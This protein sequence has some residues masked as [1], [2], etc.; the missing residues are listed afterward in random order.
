MTH[1]DD[2]ASSRTDEAVLKLVRAAGDSSRAELAAATG[3]A[4]STINQAVSR[5]L[6]RGLLRQITTSPK[7]AGSGSGRPATRLAL[8][9]SSGVTA[10][11]DFGHN[12]VRVAVADARDGF[13]A[14]RELLIDVDLRGTEAMETAATLLREL[15]SEA[16]KEM[17][18]AL[19]VGIPGP[20]DSRTGLVWSPTILSSWIGMAPAATLGEL[21][22]TSIRIENDAFLGAYGELRHGV[23][24]WAGTFLYV[25]VSNGVGASLVI[26]G[27]PFRGVSGLSGEIGHIALPNRTEVCRCGNRGCLEAVVSVGA[28]TAQIALTRQDPSIDPFTETRP[29]SPSYRVF[30]ESGRILG[31]VLA[32]CCDLLNPNAVVLGGELGANSPAFVDGVR[33][34]IERHAQPAVAGALR[35]LAAETGG[36]A[37]IVGAMA[38]A[39]VTA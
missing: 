35:V 27:K 3:I 13:S 21:L 30:E 9:R 20:V 8:A 12:H 34:S 18:P 11:I 14:E 26:D 17:P 6:G 4:Q 32:A 37:E 36:R 2:L 22:G 5:L 19:V 15:L 33:A 7:G 1:P 28:V 39:E 38:L 10:A 25:K 16:G 31:R 29:G 24:R 23:G